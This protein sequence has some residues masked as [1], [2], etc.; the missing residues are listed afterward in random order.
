MPA[1]RDLPAGCRLHGRG[2]LT[3]IHASKCRA[4]SLLRAGLRRCIF[5]TESPREGE[6]RWKR[7]S[8]PL[9]DY[10]LRS[11]RVTVQR[12]LPV[13]NVVSGPTRESPST[14]NAVSLT[15]NAVSPLS[16]TKASRCGS[17][18]RA[19]RASLE[20]GSQSLHAPLVQT[21]IRLDP[22]DERLNWEASA[23]VPRLDAQ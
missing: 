8:A 6:T 18:G 9:F 1:G 17:S 13:R 5:P 15:C 23:N 16:L 2:D 7:W 21:C 22:R 11:H 12:I 10:A 20:A 19:E 14:N 3:R 4:W